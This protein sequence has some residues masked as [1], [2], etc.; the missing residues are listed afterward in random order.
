MC[1]D[2]NYNIVNILMAFISTI[3]VINEYEDNLKPVRWWIIG[4]NCI[5]FRNNYEI[6]RYCSSGFKADVGG[7]CVVEWP[8]ICISIIWCDVNG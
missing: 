7:A 5:S 1:S 2:V 4:L 3:L 8:I 6:Y